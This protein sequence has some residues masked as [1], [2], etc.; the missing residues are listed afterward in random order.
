MTED[1]GSWIELKFNNDYEIYDQYPYPIRKKSTGGILKECI[2][3]GGYVCVSIKRRIQSK[4]RLIALQFIENDDTD[5]KTQID[6]INRNK[7]DNRIENLRWVTA[8]ENNKNKNKVIRRVDEYIDEIPENAIE[9]SEHDGFKFKDLF[10]D[11]DDE[12]LLKIVKS[13]I[14]I[15]KPYLLNKQQVI[16]LTDINGTRIKRSYNKL[17]QTFKKACDH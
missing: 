12:R 16:N 13:K 15:I 10:Y 11:I 1:V 8:S 9:I 6:H 17:I 4:H 14:K 7:L 2:H 3:G 5:N